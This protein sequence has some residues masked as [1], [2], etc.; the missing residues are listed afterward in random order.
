MKVSNN[1]DHTK[2]LKLSVTI[3]SRI[4]KGKWYVIFGEKIMFSSLVWCVH[5][6]CD[7]GKDF[8]RDDFKFQNDLLTG[9]KVD[10]LTRKVTAVSSKV[11]KVTFAELSFHARTMGWTIIHGCASGLTAVIASKTKV[12]TARHIQHLGRK[13]NTLATAVCEMTTVRHLTTIRSYKSRK[14]TTFV[15]GNALSSFGTLIDSFTVRK[16]AAYSGP[17]II[18]GTFVKCHAA[19]VFLST[20]SG[21]KRT[22]KH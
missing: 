18:T 20:A 22:W 6:S 13:A 14:A 1:F 15:A 21:K 4:V 11:S 12:A 16:S 17:A 3:C 19:T 2:A 5:R 7:L 9:A 10:S 8:W